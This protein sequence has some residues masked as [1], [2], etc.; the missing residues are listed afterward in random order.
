MQKNMCLLETE[1]TSVREGQN[2]LLLEMHEDS[3]PLK[4]KECCSKTYEI[5]RLLRSR[6]DFVKDGPQQ[7]QRKKLGCPGEPNVRQR[8]L[9]IQVT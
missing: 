1:K 7:G 2:S 3:P 9:Q 5:S 8:V 4:T 6:W